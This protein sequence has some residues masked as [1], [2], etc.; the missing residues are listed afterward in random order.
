MKWLIIKKCP[1][2]T[3]MVEWQNFCPNFDVIVQLLG[4]M[5]FWCQSLSYR[6]D[7]DFLK[8][9]HSEQNF[10]LIKK[11]QVF[12]WTKWNNLFQTVIAN[13]FV[14]QYQPS[15]GWLVWWTK[16]AASY[17]SV[18]FVWFSYSYWVTVSPPLHN[19]ISTSLQLKYC[20]LSS[21][22]EHQT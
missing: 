5:W 4:M 2:V 7:A 10:H 6:D 13:I 3:L 18:C 21:T 15:V 1:I 12:I 17:Y 19:Y 8:M 14:C 22:V 9:F 20:D 16:W 11:L